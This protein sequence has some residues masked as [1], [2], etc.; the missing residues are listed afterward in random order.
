MHCLAALD[1]LHVGD[2]RCRVPSENA[3]KARNASTAYRR[4]QRS[5]RTY[6]AKSRAQLNTIKAAQNR[7]GEA[8]TQKSNP[9]LQGPASAA[10]AA[11]VALAA[12]A[13]MQAAP[14]DNALCERSNEEGT[15][16]K[17]IKG[18]PQKP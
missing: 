4:Y 9:Q 17:P 16:M 7:S 10:A 5:I 8:S 14:K 11:A 15:M 3:S 13:A 18:V 6:G 1:G 2:G 12:A